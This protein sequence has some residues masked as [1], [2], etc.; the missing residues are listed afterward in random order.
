[1]TRIL[2]IVLVASAAFAFAA[3]AHATIPLVKS[4][5]HVSAEP[6]FI[7]MPKDGGGLTLYNAT[8]GVVARCDRKGD[9][10]ANCK[11]E[12]SVTLDDLMN[13]WVRAYQNL[14]K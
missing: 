9:A 7:Q 8:G 12:P 13:A 4:V 6:A 14:D 2:A 3:G 10:F 1:M 11:L 5:H